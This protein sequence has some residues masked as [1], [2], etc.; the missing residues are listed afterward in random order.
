MSFY[1]FQCKKCGRWS[2][3]EVRKLDSAVFKCPYC[4]HQEKIKKKSD[5]GLSL[6]YKGGFDNPNEA[7]IIALA[8]NKI[9][10]ADEDGQCW[11]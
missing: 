3:R 2:V 9:M 7:S 1:V 4:R 10:G 6:K 11:R 8:E 5:F